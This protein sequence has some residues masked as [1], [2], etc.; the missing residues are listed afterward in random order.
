MILKKKDKK[1]NNNKAGSRNRI[2]NEL[3]HFDLFKTY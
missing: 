3:H 2:T 1:N